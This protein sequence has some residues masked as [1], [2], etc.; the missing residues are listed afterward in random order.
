MLQGFPGMLVWFAENR[1]PILQNR[2]RDHVMDS[3]FNYLNGHVKREYEP[4]K[5][6]TDSGAYT[7]ARKGVKLDPYR[8]IE[9]QEKLDSDVAIPLDYPFIPG[10]SLAE[11]RRS[12]EKTI[13]N[14]KL[15]SEVMRP[16]IEVMPIVHAIGKRNLIE[17]VRILSKISDGSSILGLG[18]IVD[19]TFKLQGFLGDRQLKIEI[20]DM[21]IEGIRVVKDF[22]YK[23]HIAGFGSSPFTLHLAIYLGVDS[24]DSSGYRRRAA[25]GKIILPHTGERYVGNGQ[26]KFGLAPPSNSEVKYL[27]DSCG[28]P[29]CRNDPSL[30]WKDWRAR[31]IHNEWVIKEAWKQGLTLRE[32]GLDVYER[33]LDRLFAGSWLY[34]LWKHV[35]IRAKYKRLYDLN[36]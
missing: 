18:T 21:L 1:R 2:R 3:A 24:T 34:H 7:A 33:Y 10:M 23:V 15:W 30:L 5:L 11:M 6:L 19:P 12:W 8:I 16:K 31:A 9:I 36:C 4:Y 22:G 20:V 13:E 28:C 26:A 32:E 27:H 35:K 14:A 17:T 29:V 25:Y